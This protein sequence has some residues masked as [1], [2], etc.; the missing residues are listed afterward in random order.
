MT[1]MQNDTRANATRRRRIRI[2]LLTALGLL[3]LPVVL[4]G[5]LLALVALNHLHVA[6]VEGFEVVNDSGDTIS[7]TPVGMWEGTGDYGPLP[8]YRSRLPAIPQLRG[9]ARRQ[10]APNAS[11]RFLYDYDDINFRHLLVRTAAGDVFILDTDKRGSLDACYGPQ[12]SSYRVPPLTELATAPD[13]LRP[14]LHGRSVAYSAA[15]QYP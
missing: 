5:L 3:L 1:A 8:L 2:I 7:V 4:F 10:L 14:C 13:E 12:R 9:R 11:C 6:F 15:K